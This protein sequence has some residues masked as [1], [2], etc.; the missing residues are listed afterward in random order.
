VDSPA[1]ANVSD[2][3]PLVAAVSGVLIVSAV[4]HTQRGSAVDF[5]KQLDLLEGNVFGV[6]ANLVASPRRGYY[7]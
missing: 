3:R 5:R 6:V 4:G 1:L 7:Y 2:A